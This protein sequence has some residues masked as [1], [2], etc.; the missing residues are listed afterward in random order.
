MSSDIVGSIKL[1]TMLSGMPELRLGLND[2]VLF[3]LTGRKYQSF[4][5]TLFEFIGSVVQDEV[6]RG[7][8][9]LCVCR[10]QREDCYH[11]GC[12]VS[13]VCPSFAFREW[14]NHL[15]HPTWRRVRA[16]VIPYQHTRKAPAP[17]HQC[18]GWTTILTDT[19]DLNCP[20][21][22]T[23]DTSK[24]NRVWSQ[25]PFLFSSCSWVKP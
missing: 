16:H 19:F 12:E 14:P 13:S 24:L 5:N 17:A 2:R 6:S 7:N 3:A 1:K 20:L 8:N 9:I 25:F 4:L 15:L 22:T 11:G 18:L 23:A 10:R 21:C